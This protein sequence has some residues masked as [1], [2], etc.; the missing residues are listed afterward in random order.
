MS[1]HTAGC[2]RA[3]Q[4][5]SS[6]WASFHWGLNC[7]LM[8][9][10]ETPTAKQ[11]A[12]PSSLEHKV[13]ACKS[14]T[15]VWCCGSLGS[16]LLPGNAA[17]AERS[18]AACPAWC[19]PSRALKPAG[20]SLAAFTLRA[21]CSYLPLPQ[22]CGLGPSRFSMEVL[23]VLQKPSQGNKSKLCWKGRVTGVCLDRK[24]HA[25]YQDHAEGISWPDVLALGPMASFLL[26]CLKTYTACD[27]AVAV[28][29]G[30][31]VIHIYTQV[32]CATLQFHVEQLL[33]YTGVTFCVIVIN[34]SVVWL[35]LSW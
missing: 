24:F 8:G 34:I 13:T 9:M 25:G 6:P 15:S 21:P 11:A 12:A 29:L 17:I 27:L 20:E 32:A 18:L 16:F 14:Y 33:T 10:A 19:I 26:L 7:T 31:C 3:S 1:H 5:C 35:L 22:L 4:T 23:N 2:F 28:I 30:I